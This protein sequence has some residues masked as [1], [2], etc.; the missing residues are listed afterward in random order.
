MESFELGYYRKIIEAMKAIEEKDDRCS[1]RVFYN[2]T[3]QG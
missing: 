2:P 3:E 1:I